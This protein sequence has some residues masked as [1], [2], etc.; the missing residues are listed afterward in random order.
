[1]PAI[2]WNLPVVA[3]AKYG[4]GMRS[5]CAALL[6]L[7]LPACINL[8]GLSDSDAGA[9][10]GGGDAATTTDAGPSVTGTGCTQDLGGGAVLCTETSECKGLTVDH[11]QF[12]NCGFR[13]HGTAIVIE[14]VCDNQLCPLGVPNNCT[15]AKDMLDTQNEAQVCAQV[16]EQGRCAPL[17]TTQTG[18]GAPSSSC[19]KACASECGGNPSCMQICGC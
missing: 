14:C 18:A 17:S 8:P 7:A 19:D 16:N 1:V 5:F 11:D 12:P 9:T 10:S 15:Q 4:S 2:A 6:A 13:I 3:P